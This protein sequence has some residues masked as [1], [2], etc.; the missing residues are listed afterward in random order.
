MIGACTLEQPALGPCARFLDLSAHRCAVTPS[1]YAL[2][3]VLWGWLTE[4]PGGRVHARLDVGHPRNRLKVADELGGLRACRPG[5][6][7]P[8]APLQQMQLVES[9][10]ANRQL[11]DATAAS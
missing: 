2:S 7:R 8:A 11:S 3:G 6:D 5:I 10:Q 4:H 9:L 1:L